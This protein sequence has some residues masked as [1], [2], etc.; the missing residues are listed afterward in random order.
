MARGEEAGAETEGRGGGAGVVDEREEGLGTG[1]EKGG[2]AGPET[3]GGEAGAEIEEA[4]GGAG[5][6]IGTG[7]A[8][9][10]REERIEEDHEEEEMGGETE[11]ET[12]GWKP[13]L[14]LHQEE[15][16]EVEGE[17]EVEDQEDLFP[18]SE[19]WVMYTASSTSATSGPPPLTCPSHQRR[20][21]PGPSSACS[22]ARGA[23]PG[24]WRISSPAW[25][26]SGM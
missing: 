3:R 18:L 4:R 2:G 13:G 16:E 6:E 22:S 8:E 23:E 21:T 17:E 7:G 19:G 12:G 20:E 5:P 25:G 9:A 24:T 1:A 26:R 10:G 11:A 15:E 14:D